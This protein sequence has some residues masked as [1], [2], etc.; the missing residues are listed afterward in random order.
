MKESATC[1]QCGH[2]YSYPAELDVKTGMHCA[3]CG[4]LI[5]VKTG[6]PFGEA[7]A[8]KPEKTI[9]KTE[10]L[11]PVR[12]KAPPLSGLDAEG[13]SPLEEALRAATVRETDRTIPTVSYL[14]WFLALVAAVLAFTF[15]SYGNDAT[16]PLYMLQWLPSMIFGCTAA[17]LFIQGLATATRR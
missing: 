15:P 3:S 1:S 9:K 4:V 17:I 10:P 6:L 8:E 13:R 5:Y 11:P 16:D 2:G 12:R 7:L 14:A